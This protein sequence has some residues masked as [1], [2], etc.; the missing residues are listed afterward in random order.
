MV[1][2]GVRAG[3]VRGEH[4][5]DRVTRDALHVPNE[6]AVVG[7]GAGDRVVR[8]ERV[9]PTVTAGIQAVGAPR[10]RHEL[11]DALRPDRT[12]RGRVEMTLLVELRRQQRGRQLC[13][14]VAVAVDQPG[15]RGGHGRRR[16]PA[17]SG[18]WAE[19]G[20]RYEGEHDG[21]GE[22]RDRGLPHD[23]HGYFTFA[24]RVRL[25]AGFRVAPFASAAGS[26]LRRAG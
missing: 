15:V 1:D 2:D 4:Q 18:A 20:D 5:L 8:I 17:I 14:G 24:T 3:V 7:R 6:L 10:A 11:G 13:A 21:R 9:R 16:E 12:D 25:A 23:A 22:Q 19:A 26:S